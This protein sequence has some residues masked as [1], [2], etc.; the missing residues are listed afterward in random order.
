MSRIIQV[1]GMGAVGLVGSAFLIL[2][3]GEAL[4]ADCPPAGTD[5]FESDMAI[6]AQCV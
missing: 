5:S 6:L 1:L 4:A 2:T 3:T